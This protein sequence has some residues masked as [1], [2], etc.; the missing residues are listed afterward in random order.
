MR[1]GKAAIAVLLASLVASLPVRAQAPGQAPAAAPPAYDSPPPAAPPVVAPDGVY[2]V[3]H[4]SSP[5]V[6]IDRVVGQSAQV[7]VCVAPCR[8][9]LPR[10]NI[11][12]IDGAGIRATSRFMLPDDRNQLTLDVDAGSSAR[13]GVGVLLTIVGFGIAYVGLLAVAANSVS[14]NDRG[15]SAALVA[16]GFGAGIAGVYLVSTSHTTVVSSTGSVFTRAPAR[17][18]A[19][20]PAVALTPRGLEF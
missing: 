17:P 6:R 3:I 2:V 1:A 15:P 4:T 12:V 9:V 16:G 10:N 8:Q 13:L 7:P 14:G 11:Y 18:R 19:R 5:G 20:R